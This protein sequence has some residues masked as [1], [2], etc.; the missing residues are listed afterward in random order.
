M[1]SYRLPRGDA[2]SVDA[3][4]LASALI[5]DGFSQV[6]FY[7]ICVSTEALPIGLIVVPFWDDLSH[8]TKTGASVT[9]RAAFHWP[10]S[11]QSGQ[12]RLQH[13]GTLCSGTPFQIP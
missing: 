12:F 11:R 7:T 1:R 4:G 8:K 13:D 3:C 6:F 9:F 5:W 10:V 2:R